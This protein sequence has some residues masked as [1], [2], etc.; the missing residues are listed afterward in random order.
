MTDWNTR[1]LELE[2][3][4]IELEASL[5]Q[6]EDRLE[7]PHS[8]DFEELATEHEE[9]EVLE[10]LG[11]AGLQEIRMIRFALKR[12]EDNTYGV[13]QKC[14]SDILRERLDLLP[15]TPLCRN[16]ANGKSD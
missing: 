10:G 8:R 11:N 15:F 7:E 9:T 13:C 12:I 14:G 6:I 3:R 5:H 1:K 4:L 16:C 2:T